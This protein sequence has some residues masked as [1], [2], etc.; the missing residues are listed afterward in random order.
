MATGYAYERPVEDL[1]TRARIRDAAMDEFGEKGFKGATMK[2]IA[3]AA[4]VSVGLVQHHFGTKDGLRAAC[5][6]W[7]L[8]LLRFKTEAVLDET[9]AQPSALGVFRNIAPMLQRY[10]GRALVDDSPR[11][12]QLVDEVMTRSEQFLVAEWPERFPAGDQKTVDTAAVL[13]AMNSSIMV[14]QAHLARRMDIE[15]FTDEA[16]VRIG[17]ATFDAFEAIAEFTAT[18]FWKQ[19][20]AAVDSVWEK[21]RG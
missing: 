5:D 16:I 9:F 10:V 2:S 11:M 6:E 21:E 14:L 7:V 1:S 12:T 17:R 8:E 18:D 19:L 13:T 20:R 4:G 3:T 15:P